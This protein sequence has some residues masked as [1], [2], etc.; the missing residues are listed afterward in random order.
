MQISYDLTT[1]LETDQRVLG[2]GETAGPVEDQ[3]DWARKSGM[4][5][6]SRLH[7]PGSERC[8]AKGEDLGRKNE[9]WEPAEYRIRRKT[10]GGVSP[11]IDPTMGKGPG[12]NPARWCVRLLE[13]WRDKKFREG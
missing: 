4:A 1:A 13:N 3:E 9:G 11:T 7:G 5:P 2:R 6:L 12:R 10:C 8:G